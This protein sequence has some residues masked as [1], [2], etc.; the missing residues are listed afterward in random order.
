[1]RNIKDVEREMDMVMDTLEKLQEAMGL[2]ICERENLIALEKGR[3][4]SAEILTE[5]LIEKVKK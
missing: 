1:M 2:L 4:A 3:Q 5:K